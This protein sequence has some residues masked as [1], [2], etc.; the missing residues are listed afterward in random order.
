MR[1]CIKRT[2]YVGNLPGYARL[3]DVA[4]V[5]CEVIVFIFIFIFFKYSWC[6]F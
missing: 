6:G 3:K 5:F 2:V 4:E 1:R